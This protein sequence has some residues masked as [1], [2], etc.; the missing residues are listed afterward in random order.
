M[1]PTD[2]LRLVSVNPF[3]H[4]MGTELRTSLAKLA[5]IHDHEHGEEIFLPRQAPH[6][7]Y[8]VVSGVVEI[9]RKPQPDSEPEPVAYLGPGAI[10]GES[11]IITG[12]TF[13]STARFPEGGVTLQ[14]RRHL[15][16]RELHRSREFSLRYLHNLATRLEG[17]FANLGVW[18][19]TKL[20]GNLDHFDLPSI[21]QT[22]VESGTVGV[23]EVSDAQG[24]KFGAIHLGDRQ[25]GPM[26]CGALSGANAFLEILVSPP[27]KGRFSF[28][29]TPTVTDT[30]QRYDLHGLLF[31]AMRIAD[32]YRRFKGEV[33]ENVT[34]LPALAEFEWSGD[35]D[36]KLIRQ[37][38]NVISTGP[39]GWGKV[40]A[41][42]SFSRGQVALA[43]RDM[44]K[45]GVLKLGSGCQRPGRKVVS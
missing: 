21:L 38:W 3:F 32:E 5:R 26:R 13:N 10:L 35:G 43:V 4:T 44:L 33:A 28:A 34:L 18:G 16:L 2:V 25:V 30:A 11:K 9:S 24:K 12:T 20:G 31:E 7:L 37:V 19:S 17:T 39:S 42:V 27:A 22:V 15:I 36:E 29:S 45:A 41:S 8:M 6:A 14:W 23:L 40:A 1:G